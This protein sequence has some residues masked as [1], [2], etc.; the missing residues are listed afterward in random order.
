ME[1]GGP[2][3]REGPW[4]G[5]QGRGA[6]VLPWR[7]VDGWFLDDWVFVAIRAVGAFPDVVPFTSRAIPEV[8]NV[9]V[10]I[11]LGSI[12]LGTGEVWK[13]VL[14]WIYLPIFQP[15]LGGTRLMLAIL[16]LRGAGSVGARGLVGVRMLYF[17]LLAEVNIAVL[18][19]LK[20]GGRMRRSMVL[21]CMVPESIREIFSFSQRI[22]LPV[23]V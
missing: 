15:R 4:A 10:F 13:F 5:T 21:D 6:E 19:A 22:F 20:V 3:T 9:P 12:R 1:D 23:T 18:A 16:G 17:V 11:F 7:I 8:A 14:V 2:R